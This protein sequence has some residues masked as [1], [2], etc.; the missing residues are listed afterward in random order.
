VKNDLVEITEGTVQTIR[1]ELVIDD[2]VFT[3][4]GTGEE[5]TPIAA[6]GAAMGGSRLG[7]QPPVPTGSRGGASN[8]GLLMRIAGKVGAVVTDDRTGTQ[9]FTIDD[10]SGITSNYVDWAG[11]TQTVPGVKVQ[12]DPTNYSV[13]DILGI[14]GVLSVDHAPGIFQRVL[15]P[16][17]N[18][19]INTVAE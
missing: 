12:F 6:S 18:N 3:I 11:V 16:R 4:V 7:D 19:D 10:G 15:L 8:V 13:G 17:D 5:I 1:G 14:T 2:A 9:W